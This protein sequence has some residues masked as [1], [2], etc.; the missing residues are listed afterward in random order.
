MAAQMNY[1]FVKIR[2]GEVLAE[3]PL[4]GVAITDRLPGA[5]VGDLRA[6]WH[7]DSTGFDN[8][9]VKTA[10]TPGLCYCIVERNEAPE[11]SSQGVAIW[12]DI[13]WSRTYQ[14]QAKVVQLYCKSLV[15]YPY[16]R[17]M[18][19][20]VA[21]GVDQLDIFRNLWNLM[22]GEA[23]SNLGVVVAGSYVTGAP[24]LASVDVAANDFKTYGDQF[25][26]L[27][28]GDQGF[29]WHIEWTRTGGIYTPT[30]RAQSP[31]LGRPL[32][33]DTL[34]FD[35]PGNILNYWETDSCSDAGTNI[36]TMGV[37]QGDSMIASTVTRPDLID[38]GYVR[39]DIA[40]QSKTSTDQ[41]SVDALAVQQGVLH[42][43][44]VN[45]IK[46]QVKADKAPAFGSWSLGDTAKLSLEDAWHSTRFEKVSRIVEY[47]YS[48]PES[49]QVEEVELI[50]EGVQN[51]S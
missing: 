13:V 16:C 50:F 48:P 7:M 39:I 36:V 32:T 15:G 29:D 31:T 22:Q 33:D 11:V 2:T 3:I 35:Y 12:G 41:A 24:V 44:P 43:M 26:D 49:D 28:N 17:F 47:S 42:A 20:Y 45:T 23:G 6:T 1:V 4:E 21:T 18:P 10:M 38:A 8:D 19:D 37:G 46:V 25:D 34:T 14:S 27:A 9:T 40:I 51:D 5:G 30:L